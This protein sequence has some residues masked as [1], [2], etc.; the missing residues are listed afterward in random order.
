MSLK[1]YIYTN[2]GYNNSISFAPKL[3]EG[4]Y[5]IALRATYMYGS[6]A[7]GMIYNFDCTTAYGYIVPTNKVP[8]SHWSKDS[9]AAGCTMTDKII[10]N[11]L[12]L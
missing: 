6:T 12:C 11:H 2:Y 9:E 8:S 1:S 10:M 4:Y 3:A 5:R 7:E